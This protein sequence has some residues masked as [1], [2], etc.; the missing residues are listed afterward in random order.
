MESTSN[1]TGEE[2]TQAGEDWGSASWAGGMEPW[3]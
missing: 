2:G 1:R 3:L